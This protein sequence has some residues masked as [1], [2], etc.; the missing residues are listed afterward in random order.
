MMAFNPMGNNIF[1]TTPKPISGKTLNVLRL[2]SAYPLF[3]TIGILLGGLLKSPSF[4]IF[5]MATW[6]IALYIGT[7][8]WLGLAI[9]LT[10]KK[11]IT[12]KEIL[13]HLIFVITGIIA[14]YFVYEF[15]ILN[16]GVKYKD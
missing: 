9:Y 16:S 7:L 2:L 15:D 4:V 5:I 8:T 11:K 1:T 13:L 10:L 3:W 6:V 12:T 14:A